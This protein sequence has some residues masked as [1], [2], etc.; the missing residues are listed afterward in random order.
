MTS[1]VG[2]YLL[3]EII[4]ATKTFVVD[5]LLPSEPLGQ[6]IY[7]SLAFFITLTGYGIVFKTYQRV[8]QTAIH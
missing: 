6:S 7:F 1:V 8:R 3:V 5:N 2:L 4:T